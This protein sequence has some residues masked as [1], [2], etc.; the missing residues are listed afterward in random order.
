M[1]TDIEPKATKIKTGG[2]ENPWHRGGKPAVSNMREEALE[3]KRRPKRAIIPARTSLFQ[4]SL[5]VVN[6][7]V[8]Q[9]AK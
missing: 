2:K 3:A 5:G 1:I 9:P 6:H 4:G 8:A 7:H